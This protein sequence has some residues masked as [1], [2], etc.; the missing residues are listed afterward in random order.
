MDIQPKTNDWK[1]VGLSLSHLQ[2]LYVT[3]RKVF[4]ERMGI[5]PEIILWLAKDPDGASAL[6]E[7]LKH[8]G[9][10]FFL[11][12]SRVRVVSATT[13]AVNLDVPTVFQVKDSIVHTDG[14][15]GWGMVEKRG[16]ELYVNDRKVV[17]HFEDGQKNGSVC[18]GDLFEA[19]RGTHCLHPNIMD[20]LRSHPDFI[21]PHWKFDEAGHMQRIYFWGAT[22]EPEDDIVGSGHC[23]R[24]LFWSLK[25]ASWR[26]MSTPF[27][28][29]DYTVYI[30][31]PAARLAS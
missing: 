1:Q 7:A 16:D 17:L 26:T 22:F 12:L 23:V 14:G 30:K 18:G 29:G 11:R 31:G 21:P 25:S 5:G 9:T 28:G 19:L 10:E 27:S 20:A 8:L 24:F 6:T 3:A 2:D 13:I 4:W 15:T